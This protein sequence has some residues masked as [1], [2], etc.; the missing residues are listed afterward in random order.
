MREVTMTKTIERAHATARQMKEK[1]EIVWKK[2]DDLKAA[3]SEK[4][5]S[6][7]KEIDAILRDR[8]DAYR[9]AVS[10]VK[11]DMERS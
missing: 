4:W 2:L 7:K 6:I 3:G 9:K 10:K 5:E 1:S 11:S 8:E